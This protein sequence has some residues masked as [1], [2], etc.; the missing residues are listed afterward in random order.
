MKTQAKQKEESVKPESC[1]EKDQ[2][3]IAQLKQSVF[4]G[5]SGTD[6]SGCLSL[7]RVRE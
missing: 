6:Q 1:E 3:M 5:A 4:W 2:T 7:G